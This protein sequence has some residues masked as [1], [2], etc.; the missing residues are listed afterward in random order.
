MSRKRKKLLRPSQS[1]RP[2]QKRDW[3]NLAR[4][5][6]RAGGTGRT[7]RICICASDAE[8]RELKRRAAAVGLSI[9]SYLLSRALSD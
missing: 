9:T 2:P 8:Y 4:P 1:K 6:R 7:R 3:R 5:D